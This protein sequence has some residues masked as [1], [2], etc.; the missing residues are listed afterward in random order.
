MSI[1]M[2][3]DRED[4]LRHR[5]VRSRRPGRSHRTPPVAAAPSPHRRLPR[6]GFHAHR[7][8]VRPETRQRWTELSPLARRA[9]GL[10]AYRQVMQQRVPEEEEPDSKPEPGV[11]EPEHVVLQES[12]RSMPMH[13]PG[14]YR[15]VSRDVARYLAVRSELQ[16]Y[17]DASEKV[18]ELMGEGVVDV[19]E[20]EFSALAESEYGDVWRERLAFDAD[21]AGDLLSYVEHPE[22][23]HLF[24]EL[25]EWAEEA[26]ET[27]SS[28]EGA[29]DGLVEE[30]YPDRLH[31]GVKK[32]APVFAVG[33]ALMLMSPV[34]CLMGDEDGED[35][36]AVNWD[37]FVRDVNQAVTP[38]T[39]GFDLS[40]LSPIGTAE[41]HTQEK[42]GNGAYDIS[43]Q[44]RLTGYGGPF[45]MPSVLPSTPADGPVEDNTS[46][47]FVPTFDLEAQTGPGGENHTHIGN[48]VSYEFTLDDG[49][50]RVEADV[51]YND[52]FI[53]GSIKG[54]DLDMYLYG[55]N[56]NIINSHES[57]SGN[58]FITEGDLSAGS[59]NL[60]L[61]AR[62]GQAPYTTE[63]RIID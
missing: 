37:D 48:A 60:L 38:A 20:E 22:R 3:I 35:G 62:H 50:N 9:S 59:Y 52:L 40:M 49:S 7:T 10:D 41:A 53:T 25:E 14:T 47:V 26:A 24:K 23:P 19:F 5:Q 57:D 44:G 39:N 2:A 12:V 56:G 13:R 8:A 4:V 61:V 6:S 58:L 27:G 30:M 36:F 42:T 34:G 31:G 55:P 11:V 17:H 54:A 29:A 18:E 43:D 1:P 33:S 45:V 15:N 51:E 32:Y 16:A 28:L 46:D 21:A 63:I